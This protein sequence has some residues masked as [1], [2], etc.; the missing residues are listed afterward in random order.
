M[1]QVLQFKRSESITCDNCFKEIQ[2]N[3]ANIVW[4]FSHSLTKNSYLRIILFRNGWI[5]NEIVKSSTVNDEEEII[6]C[7]TVHLCP[8]CNQLFHS[9]SSAEF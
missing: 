5:K 3:T 8:L 1:A 7:T 2:A 6:N 4:D 9:K